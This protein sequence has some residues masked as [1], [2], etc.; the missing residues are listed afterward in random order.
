MV[1]HQSFWAAFAAMSWLCG[2]A[3]TPHGPLAATPQAAVLAQPA[4]TQADLLHAEALGYDEGLAAGKRVQARRD[5]ALA[6]SCA[7]ATS[8]ASLPAATPVSMPATASVT[9][10]TPVAA[11]PVPVYEPAGP[12]VPLPAS[13]P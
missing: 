12:A 11:A 6:A 1:Q 8:P 2:C 7:T 9:L 4:I 5:H 10:A 3:A 13:T